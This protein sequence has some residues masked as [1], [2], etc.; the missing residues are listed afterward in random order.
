[1]IFFLAAINSNS[2]K[3]THTHI[4][5]D[6]NIIRIYMLIVISFIFNVI[7]L[8]AG[9]GLYN[10]TVELQSQVTE[11]ACKARQS[12][13]DIKYLKEVQDAMTKIQNVD[14]DLERRHNKSD[15]DSICELS[16]RILKLEDTAERLDNVTSSE[17]IRKINEEIQ[18]LKQDIKSLRWDAG[19]LKFKQAN[20]LESLRNDIKNLEENLE[21]TNTFQWSAIRKL[22][23]A[24]PWGGLFD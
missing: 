13:C 20:R 8:F 24:W 3:H 22:K 11:A 1:M 16:N 6:K 23:Q 14:R 21:I 17:H 10:R 18:Q 9:H 12:E 19:E 5:K 4:M 7:L 2:T 15:K